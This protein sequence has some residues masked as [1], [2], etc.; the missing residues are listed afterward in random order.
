M[1]AKF[2]DYIVRYTDGSYT[3]FAGIYDTEQ[4]VEYSEEREVDV[5]PPSALILGVECDVLVHRE[6]LNLILEFWNSV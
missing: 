4:V 5:V 6:K 1:K 2:G 3:L